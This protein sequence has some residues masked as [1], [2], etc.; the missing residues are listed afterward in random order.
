MRPE[1]WAVLLG[2]CWEMCDNI[3]QYARRIIDAIDVIG[4]DNY[5]LMMTA[6]EQDALAQLPEIVTIYRGADEGVNEIGLSWSLFQGT[7]NAVSASLAL[8]GEVAGPC[9]RDHSPRKHHCLEAG[10]ERTG[11][12]CV[13]WHRKTYRVCRTDQTPG[14]NGRRMKKAAGRG[15]RKV[16][17]SAPRSPARLHSR[18]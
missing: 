5:K 14:Q 13:A 1:E 17:R 15:C 6:E 3:A 8:P 9:H 16:L 4:P 2:E 12:D 7:G 11:S 18:V 10:P